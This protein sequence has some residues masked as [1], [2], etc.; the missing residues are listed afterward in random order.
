MR[1]KGTVH[2]ANHACPSC[3]SVMLHK[4]DI[5]DLLDY[6]P[7]GACR[8]LLERSLHSSFFNADIIKDNHK[9]SENRFVWPILLLD[10]G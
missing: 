3:L 9:L 6:F 5:S 10:L 1:D 8:V 7:G 4:L 2:Y